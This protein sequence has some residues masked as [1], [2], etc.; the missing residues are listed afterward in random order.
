MNSI[1]LIHISS[2]FAVRKVFPSV[3]YSFSQFLRAGK[4]CW[5]KVVQIRGQRPRI[6]YLHF[7]DR[8]MWSKSER[9][10]RRRVT[11]LWKIRQKP[12]R[13]SLPQPK[14]LYTV[15]NVILRISRNLLG[16]RENIK[17]ESHPSIHP[18]NSKWPT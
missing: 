17:I 10:S 15:H 12:V 6:C 2:R 9:L 11:F 3:S 13:S 14:S 8:K 16:T 18:S 4:L 7:I 1:L 5:E